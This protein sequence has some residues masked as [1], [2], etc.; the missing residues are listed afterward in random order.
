MNLHPI[1]SVI[2]KAQLQEIQKFRERLYSFHSLSN[3][4]VY[5]SYQKLYT[6]QTHGIKRKKK[7]K[8]KVSFN[9]IHIYSQN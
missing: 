7:I 2:S 4:K 6:F 5:D 1:F 8:I 3:D 9:L